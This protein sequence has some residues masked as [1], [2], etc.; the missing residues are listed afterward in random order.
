M[1][2]IFNIMAVGAVLAMLVISFG[3][4]SATSATQPKMVG[5]QWVVYGETTLPN[6]GLNFHPI[7]H[8]TTMTNGGGV[9]F[10]MPDATGS[11][12]VFVNYI[13]DA[14]TVSLTESDTITVTITV[15]STS[16]ALFMG[17]PL[18]LSDYGSAITPAFVR[19]FIQAN[20]PDNNTIGGHYG[21]LYN[22][23]W[24]DVDAYT[25]NS[26]SNTMTMNVPLNPSDW[27]S[28]YGT[29]GASVNAAFDAALLSI[30][31]VGLSFGSGYFYASGVGIEDGSG[32]TNF[33]LNS[34][35]IT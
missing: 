20:L 24:A 23:W 11:S 2:R 9:E 33:E 26:A 32:T 29:N 12:P 3:L 35:T 18:W 4:V 21:A 1:N 13:L 22:Y 31:Y 15:D 7:E 5:S 14:Y 8:A 17:N 34:F 10:T 19:I 30:K 6:G 16:G 28:I 27:S 25:F